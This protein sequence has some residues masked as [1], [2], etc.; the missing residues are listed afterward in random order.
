MKITLSFKVFFFF[1]VNNTTPLSTKVIKETVI[2]LRNFD[3][4]LLPKVIV[5]LVGHSYETYVIV[6]KVKA[7]LVPTKINT[8]TSSLLNPVCCALIDLMTV[9]DVDGGMSRAK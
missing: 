1:F 7:S 8:M 9:L 3:V 6:L 4:R 5:V 2:L